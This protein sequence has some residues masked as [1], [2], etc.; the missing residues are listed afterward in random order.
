MKIVFTLKDLVKYIIFI[1]IVYT[2]MIIIPSK[3]ISKMDLIL[4]VSV[5]SISFILLDCLNNNF[6]SFTD[7]DVNTLVPLSPTNVTAVAGNGQASVTWTVPSNNIGSSISS[8]VIKN[9]VNTNIA[10]IVDAST[11]STTTTTPTQIIKPTSTA[12]TTTVNGLTT[13]TATVLG[14]INGTPY[15][16]TVHPRNTLGL[17]PVTSASTSNSV[18]PKPVGKSPVAPILTSLEPGNESVTVNY[19]DVQNGTSP[20]LSYNLY[21]NN[22]DGL[23]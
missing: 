4:I 10:T 19:L 22:R 5:I 20:I 14:L 3:E 16:F 15:T 12:T 11:F 1:G 6:E 23:S 2:L 21:V 7:T 13:I 18:T 17:L 9:N 8:Y